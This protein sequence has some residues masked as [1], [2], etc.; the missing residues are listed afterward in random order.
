MFPVYPTYSLY[1]LLG[2]ATEKRILN[3]ESAS[4]SVLCNIK[5]ITRTSTYTHMFITSRQSSSATERY[6]DL[7]PL[8]STECFQ[9][10]TQPLPEMDYF[11]MDT[12]QFFLDPNFSFDPS[13]VEFPCMD[14]DMDMDIAQMQM[15]SRVSQDPTCIEE[16][17]GNSQQTKLKS[18]V[19]ASRACIACRTRLDP[20]SFSSQHSK[21]VF[22]PLSPPTG[23]PG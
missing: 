12:S 5:H 13:L 3:S 9:A 21:R 2:A 10:H 8:P 23:D 17:P 11:A 6:P 16:S 18:R 15:Q 4:T 22:E 20:P 14:M 19:R 1:Y 7:H